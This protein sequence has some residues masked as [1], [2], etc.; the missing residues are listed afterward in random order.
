MC[1]QKLQKVTVKNAQK[2][3][4]HVVATKHPPSGFPKG[5]KKGEGIGQPSI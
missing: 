2:K 1:N 5:N 3:T 4:L